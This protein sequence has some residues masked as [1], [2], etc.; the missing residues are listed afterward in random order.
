MPEEK[1]LIAELVDRDNER[2]AAQSA[3]TYPK[4]SIS[5][6]EFQQLA[7]ATELARGKVAAVRVRLRSI[8]AAKGRKKD[9]HDLHKLQNA[10]NELSEEIDTITYASEAGKEQLPSPEANEAYRERYRR[11][12][13]IREK[14]ANLTFAMASVDGT[15]S[16]AQ[17]DVGEALQKLQSA[18]TNLVDVETHL[19][20]A[21]G[22]D[23]NDQ[24]EL[25]RRRFPRAMWRMI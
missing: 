21:E 13:T 14:L 1:R 7:M 2:I 24:H 8:R 10:P 12:E 19:N 15:P 25:P 16:N 9:S 23:A 6:E 11:L 20:K 5:P 4:Y 18:Q 17:S 3:L 22:A